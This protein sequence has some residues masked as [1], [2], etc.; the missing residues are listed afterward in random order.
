VNDR[1]LAL[2]IIAIFLLS[3]SAIAGTII[4]AQALLISEE[5]HWK[6]RIDRWLW[7]EDRRRTYGLVT[8]QI[9]IQNETADRLEGFI[10]D[11]NGTRLKFYDG[12]QVVQVRYLSNRSAVSGWEIAGSVYDGYFSIDIPQQYREAEIVRIIIG[13]HQY[14]VDNGTP[15]TP[16]TEVYFNSAM[17]YYRTNSTFDQIAETEVAQVEESKP[18]SSILSRG[19][20]IDYILS[21]HGMLPV[22]SADSGE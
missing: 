19:S 6:Y 14:T 11:V 22:R 3:G 1:K 2:S 8:P 18:V 15:T 20:L 9:V 21:T 7:D 17:L 13:K 10:A 16:Q 5:E 12:D 4:S